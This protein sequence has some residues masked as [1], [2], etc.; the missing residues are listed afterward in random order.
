M[1]K[2]NHGELSLR[3]PGGLRGGAFTN[4]PYGMAAPRRRANPA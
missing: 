4:A 3:N 1:A 2:D